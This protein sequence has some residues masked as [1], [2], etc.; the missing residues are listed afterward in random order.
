MTNNI[1]WDELKSLAPIRD[2]IKVVEHPDYA[3]E[4]Q[5]A[6]RSMHHLRQPEG[7]SR[8]ESRG[9]PGRHL[10]TDL[11]RPTLISH[12]CHGRTWEGYSRRPKRC[13]TIPGRFSST[14]PAKTKKLPAEHAGL[15]NGFEFKAQVPSFADQLKKAQRL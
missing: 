11:W 7:A 5:L 3:G 12:T 6:M 2:K 10:E 14:I 9:R 13:R 4:A 8:L 15:A 1:S